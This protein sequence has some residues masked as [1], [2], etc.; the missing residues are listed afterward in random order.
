MRAEVV[1]RPFGLVEVF[2]E[3][4]LALKASNYD[5]RSLGSRGTREGAEIPSSVLSLV[6][7]QHLPDT[8]LAQ[9]E[10]ALALEALKREVTFSICRPK[11]GFR[12]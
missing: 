8:E 4:L 2:L 7:I 11:F 5:F 6:R 12:E 1:G 9:V 10:R 3:V